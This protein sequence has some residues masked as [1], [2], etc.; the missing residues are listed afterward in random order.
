MRDIAKF[1]A[2][3]KRFREN[4]FGSNRELYEQLKQGQHPRA[5]VVGCSDSRV[6][7]A[8]LMGSDPG[9]IFAV[10]NVA[11]L[12]P[13]CEEGGGL[14]GVSAALEFA[15]CSLEVE[16]I[17]VLGHSQC[18]GIRALMEGACGC[19]NGGFIANWMRIAKPARDKV[20]AEL[21]HKPF[22]I[23]TRACEQ[24]SVLLSLDNLMTF[25]WIRQRVEAGTLHLHG[26]YFD[27][28]QG[29]LL[30]YSPAGKAFE[31]LTT[32]SG[33]ERRY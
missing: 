20:E 33:A 31:S 23:R 29:E 8:I 17:I 28:G 7:P 10:R 15:V 13:P 30:G 18:G 11:N 21:P 16:H 14:H 27:I 25:P 6:D 12:V 26:W 19:E 1:I 3:F 5:L 2:G 24:A 9:D 4:Y 32:F 22:D